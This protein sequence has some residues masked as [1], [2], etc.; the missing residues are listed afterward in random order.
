MTSV[1][2]KLLVAAAIAIVA[3]GVTTPTAGADPMSDLVAMVPPGYGPDSCHP[4]ET[5]GLARV[6]CGPNSLPGGPTVAL[7][8]IYA[9][10]QKMAGTF[11]RIYDELPNHVPCPGGIST[12]PAALNVG[13]HQIG[14]VACGDGPPEV[15]WAVNANSFVAEVQGDNLD[16]LFKWFRSVIVP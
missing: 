1:L 3:I 2:P 4:T 7:Y 8:G 11:Q 13:E 15:I 5:N 9:G 12:N 14:N 16:D 10:I 6:Q